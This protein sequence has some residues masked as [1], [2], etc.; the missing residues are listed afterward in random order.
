M[1]RHMQ[2]TYLVSYAVHLSLVTAV[3]QVVVHS[4]GSALFGQSSCFLHS[5]LI[6]VPQHQHSAVSCKLLSHEATNPT[7]CSRYQHHLTTDVLLFS[8]YEEVDERL[9][10]VPDGQQDDQ[11]RFQEEIHNG[12]MKEG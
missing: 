3:T 9:H 10:I 8:G 5:L 2:E 4:A 7:A 11:Q 1:S 12:S 6:D